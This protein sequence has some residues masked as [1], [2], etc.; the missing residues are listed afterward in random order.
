MQYEHFCESAA[1]ADERIAQ[2]VASAEVAGIDFDVA[3][4][5]VEIPKDVDVAPEEGTTEI[6]AAHRVKYARTASEI[7]REY[8][9]WCTEVLGQDFDKG[10]VVPKLK[11]DILQLMEDVFGKDENEGKRI[12]LAKGNREIFKKIVRGALDK[13]LVKIKARRREARERMFSSY[14]WEVPLERE[15]DAQTNEEVAAIIHAMEPF[16]RAKGASTPERDFEAYLE[17]NRDYLAW[18]YK[19]GDSGREHFAVPYRDWSGEKALFYVDF[20]VKAKSGT[21]YLFDA[22]TKGSDVDAPAKHNALVDFMTAESAKRKCAMKG[23][24]LIRDAGLWRY[25]PIKIKNTS[26]LTGWDAFVPSQANA[27]LS[28]SSCAR[29]RP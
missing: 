24:I 1:E 26:D 10:A 12:V 28:C 21:V 3:N 20:V 13:Y 14:E 5:R 9:R 4:V 11:G 16:V 15:Y 19:N 27:I 17:E 7:D 2:N 8:T 25:S 22:K 6:D 18:W 23:G 29:R